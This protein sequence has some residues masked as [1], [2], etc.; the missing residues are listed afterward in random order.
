MLFSQECEYNVRKKRLREGK[1]HETDKDRAERKAKRGAVDQ[2][3]GEEGQYGKAEEL[4][5]TRHQKRKE[6]YDQILR[7]G[8]GRFRKRMTAFDEQA[9]NHR[10]GSAYDASLRQDPIERLHF[11]TS[12]WCHHTIS[13]AALQ[14]PAKYFLR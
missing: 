7:E 11:T 9:K 8:H 5:G 4:V 2:K 10:N 3:F 12:R 14:P 1:Y 6:Q 13:A